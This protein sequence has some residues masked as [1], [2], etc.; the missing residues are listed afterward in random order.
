MLIGGRLVGP[1]HAFLEPAG[2]GAEKGIY[3]NEP[4]GSTATD[5]VVTSDEPRILQCLTI[6]FDAGLTAVSN[7]EAVFCARFCGEL[8][9][10]VSAAN[11][12]AVPSIIGLE[13][14]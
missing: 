6:S 12:I 3:S 7:V 8:S 11:Y 1:Q 9:F 13:F 4:C 2:P 10:R 5:G 14:A